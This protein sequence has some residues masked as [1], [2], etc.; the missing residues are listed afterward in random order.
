MRKLTPLLLFTAALSFG[1]CGH[2]IFNPFSG[3]LD[4]AEQNG[5]PNVLVQAAGPITSLAMDVTSLNL[6]TATQ[7][8]LLVQ[9]WSGTG[10]SSGSVTGTL[11]PI[12]I[13]SLNPRSLTSVTANFTSTSN[14][15]CIANSNGGV[16]PTGATGPTGPTGPA[17]ATGPQGPAGANGANGTNGLSTASY[18]LSFSTQTSNLVLVTTLASAGITNPIGAVCNPSVLL[19]FLN[20]GTNVTLSTAG[21]QNYTGTCNIYGGGPYLDPDPTLAADS[22]ARVATQAA[23]LDALGGISPLNGQ[24]VGTQMF[25]QLFYVVGT[26]HPGIASAYNACAAAIGTGSGT[27]DIWDYNL[28]H[29]LNTLPWLA[30]HSEKITVRLHLGPGVLTICDNGT[31]PDGNTCAAGFSLATG[32]SGVIDGI[33]VKLSTMDSGTI[34]RAGA[35]EVASNWPTGTVNTSGTAVTWVSGTPFQTTGWKNGQF[36]INGTY[37]VISSVTDNH[38][39]VLKSSAGTQ[40]GVSWTYGYPGALMVWGDNI[41]PDQAD[42][43]G[44]II[45]HLTVD[46]QCKAGSIGVVNAST[47]EESWL[48]SLGIINFDTLGLWMTSLRTSNSNLGALNI[49]PNQSGF[50]CLKASTMAALFA[51]AG[52]PRPQQGMTINGLNGYNVTLNGAS[53]SASAGTGTITGISFLQANINTA[54]G[55]NGAATYINLTDATDFT[56]STAGWKGTWPVL[57][58]TGCSAGTCTGMTINVGS[59]SNVGNVTGTAG[60]LQLVPTYGVVMATGSGNSSGAPGSYYSGD[61]SAA[62]AMIMQMHGLHMQHFGVGLQVDTSG[63]AE[64]LNVIDMGGSSDMNTLAT[65][66]NSASIRDVNFYNV[67]TGGAQTAVKDNLLGYTTTQNAIGSY[68]TGSPAASNGPLELWGVPLAMIQRGAPGSGQ[69]NVSGQSCIYADSTANRIEIANNG[70]SFSP[71]LLSSDVNTLFTLGAPQMTYCTG[72]ATSSSTII[73]P[74][75]ASAMACT[76]TTTNVKIPI[77]AGHVLKNLMVHASHAGV[78]SSSG[79]VT[80][81]RNSAV[82]TTLTC[83]IGTGTTCSDTTHSYT[84]A[85]NDVFYVQFTT[86]GSEVLADVVVTYEVQ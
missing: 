48:D 1:Q 30:D 33:V 6:S 10:F 62:N 69:C 3:K 7:N 32:N 81:E 19:D 73:L 29:S 8:T 24:V 74:S 28:P 44:S 22:N 5:N 61:T 38:H 54:L 36:L 26:P 2:W 84:V 17:G 51:N 15:A 72:T 63:T 55:P 41:A 47:Q 75:A 83:T 13:T 60:T 46:S 82:S 16:G 58:V 34:I 11:S 50:S 49:V 43:F 9:C 25:P 27:C 53:L 14:V 79:V 86:Q 40:T 45:S 64:G 4:C 56:G 71:A 35:N 39:L 18:P 37:Y 31:D 65:I 67:S 21:G 42:A 80:V 77:G 78:N 85:A 68:K 70:G 20:D 12:T 52:M 66:A 76:T 57:S 59:A 23:L